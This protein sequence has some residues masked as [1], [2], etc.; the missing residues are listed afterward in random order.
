MWYNRGIKGDEKT[1][2]ASSVKINGK[3]IKVREERVG[4]NGEIRLRAYFTRAYF[5]TFNKLK[6]KL[7]E[8]ATLAQKMGDSCPDFD[9]KVRDGN[10]E[11][12]NI[13]KIVKKGV[14]SDD[15]EGV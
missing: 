13:S 3:F 2:K 6:D 8:V 14:E 1:M 11:L 4:K 5:R 10:F 7:V 9:I 12:K 15:T